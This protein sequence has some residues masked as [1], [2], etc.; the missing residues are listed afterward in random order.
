MVESCEA[1]YH[2]HYQCPSTRIVLYY[3]KQISYEK[4]KKFMRV[5][6]PDLRN[7]CCMFEN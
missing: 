1:V 6:E 3:L 4:Y 2:C 7:V 5:I